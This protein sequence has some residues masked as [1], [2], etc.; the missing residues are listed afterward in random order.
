[1]ILFTIKW[2]MESNI[3]TVEIESIKFIKIK[4]LRIAKTKD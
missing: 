2:S 1:M 3:R 4:T